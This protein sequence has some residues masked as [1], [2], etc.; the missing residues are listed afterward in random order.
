VTSAIGA[1]IGADL[2]AFSFNGKSLNEIARIEGHHFEVINGGGGK[3][4]VIRSRWKDEKTEETF[5]WNGK[6]FEK[7]D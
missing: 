4:A 7:I 5:G 3:P 6:K 1:S 2:Q